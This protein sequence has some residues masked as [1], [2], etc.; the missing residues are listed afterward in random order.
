MA[1]RRQGL[2]KLWIILGCAPVVAGGVWAG[3]AA[4]Q[5]ESA[6]VT[7]LPGTSVVTGGGTR[8]NA[9]AQ[10]DSSE[11]ATIAAEK[12]GAVRST[13]KI[14]TTTGTGALIGGGSPLSNELG[15]ATPG[16][17]GVP[18]IT[19]TSVTEDRPPLGIEPVK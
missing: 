2:G 10:Q 11:Y 18:E 6:P 19:A 5:E 8:A 12:I 4:W 17:T 14:P 3:I 16:K 13:A 9:P 7:S 15:I 1:R